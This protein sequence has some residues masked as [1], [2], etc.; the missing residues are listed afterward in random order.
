MTTPLHKENIS[1]EK[2]EIINGQLFK[3]L[4]DLQSA[5]IKRSKIRFS[6]VFIG[7]HPMSGLGED[8]DESAESIAHSKMSDFLSLKVRNTDFVFQ[9]KSC[10]YCI[11]LLPF[12]GEEEAKYFLERIFQEGTVFFQKHGAFQEVYL[13]ASIVEIANS[14]AVFEEVL[15][16]GEQALQAAMLQEPSQYQVVDIFKEREVEKIK[17]SIIEKDDINLSIIHTLLKRSEME[18]F[19]LDIQIFQDGNEFLE[20]SWYQ[21]GHTHIVIMNDILPKKNG[22]EVLH[23][24]RRLPNN[25]KYIIIMMSKRKAEEDMIFAYEK[26]VDGY[27]IKPFNI[28]LTEAQ[29]KSILKRLRS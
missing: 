11:V 7:L 24:L 2:L 27:I 23:E 18:H 12:S 29:I 5:N 8:T 16:Q 22:I 10:K 6:L 1:V 17:V 9:H 26:G 3:I 4:F 19:D 21:S 20:S 15:Q 25:Q 28:K 13:S 14:Q